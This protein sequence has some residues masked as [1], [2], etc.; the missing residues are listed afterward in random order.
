MAKSASV[1]DCSDDGDHWKYVRLDAKKGL[2]DST[3]QTVEDWCMCAQAHE[4]ECLFSNVT[5]TNEREEVQRIHFVPWILP[6]IAQRGLPCLA[7]RWQSIYLY[8]SSRNQV[9]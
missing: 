9:N 8:I 6:V 4:C 3:K 5:C 2:I 1:H 7:E